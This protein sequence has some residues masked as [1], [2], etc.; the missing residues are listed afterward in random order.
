MS[1]FTA[2]FSRAFR[3]TQVLYGLPKAVK[4][5]A[6]TWSSETLRS[7]LKRSASNMQK[8][9][10]GRKTGQLA[11]NIGQEIEGN[12]QGYRILLGTGVGATQ[13][14]KYAR[15]SR[16]R[17]GRSGRRIRCW[18]SPAPGRRAYPLELPGCIRHPLEERERAPRAAEMEEGPRRRKLPTERRAGLSVRPQKRGHASPRRSGSPGSSRSE[19]PCSPKRWSRRRS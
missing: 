8:S 3:K 4:R 18:P 2:D 6:T 17:A 10:R 5:Q 16:T 12:S 11:K 9:G 15:G 1:K 14:V 19:S 7:F 13:S